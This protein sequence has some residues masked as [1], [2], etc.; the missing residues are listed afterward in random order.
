M[1]RKSEPEEELL[2]EILQIRMDDLEKAKEALKELMSK[3]IIFERS[4]LPESEVKR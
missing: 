4:R 2:K 3:Y 1:D